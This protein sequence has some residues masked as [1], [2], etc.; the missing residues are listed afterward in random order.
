MYPLDD[1]RGISKFVCIR[2]PN[3]NT[4]YF[5]DSEFSE[6]LDTIKNGLRFKKRLEPSPLAKP[7]RLTENQVDIRYYD[8]DGYRFYIL[9]ND[10]RK[11]ILRFHLNNNK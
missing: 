5:T 11:Q 8:F 9:S 3:Q 4:I 2:N 10:C 1:L 6:F 7:V